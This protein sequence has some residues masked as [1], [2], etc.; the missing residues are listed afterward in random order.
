MNFVSDALANGRHIK[1]LTVADDFTRECVDLAVDHGISGAYVVRLLD[2]APVSVTS[3]G[4]PRWRRHGTWL[5]SLASCPVRRQLTG[6][7]T[8]KTQYSQQS[9]LYQ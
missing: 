2:Q 5:R 7:N 8:T 1:C 9:G 3:T 6:H 4:S